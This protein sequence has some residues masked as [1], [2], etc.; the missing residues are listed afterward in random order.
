VPTN[1]PTGLDTVGAGGT[2][3]PGFVNAGPVVNPAQN[4]DAVIRNN[5]NLGLIATQTKLGIDGDLT[6]TSVDWGLLGAGGTPNQGLQFAAAG[7]VF[8]GQQADAG[9]FLHAATNLPAFH[10]AGD[11]V[12]TYYDVLTTYN[13]WLQTNVVFN[14]TT[15]T[16]QIQFLNAVYTGTGAPTTDGAVFIR[17]EPAATSLPAL[18]VF[19]LDSGNNDACMGIKAQAS[20]VGTA[21]AG[22]AYQIGVYSST[23]ATSVAAAIARGYDFYAAAPPAPAGPGTYHSYGFYS[24]AGHTYGFY[25]VS[26][27]GTGFFSNS[28]VYGFRAT[29]STHG[30]YADAGN[31]YNIHL[32]AANLYD[33]YTAQTIVEF[34]FKDNTIDKFWLNSTGISDGR[35]STDG[36]LALSFPTQSHAVAQMISSWSAAGG[37]DKLG[38]IAYKTTVTSGPT[39]GTVGPLVAAGVM[40]GYEAAHA[41]NKDD[42]A[43]STHR[44]FYSAFTFTN[45]GGGAVAD[46]GGTAYGLHINM[47]ETIENTTGHYHNNDGT[48]AFD[49]WAINVEA[50]ESKL[51]RTLIEGPATLDKAVLHL[52]QQ[53]TG[54]FPIL[55]LEG[56]SAPD[57]TANFDTAAIA[58]FTYRGMYRVSVVDSAGTLNAGTYWVPLY[59]I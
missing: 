24:A 38:G 7:A 53:N 33:I 58:G 40:T 37:S 50:G 29:G 23:D 59:T 36:M 34:T 39:A 17:M 25:S 10:Y 41:T 31:D 18:N 49:R 20:T 42:A 45:S 11:V 46:E 28:D 32:Q 16:E 3:G 21:M 2:L 56:K 15:A 8:P 55:A 48:Y 4:I 43:T 13:N 5:L 19:T 22:G 47:P 30:F 54:A 1:F 26:S 35:R 51:R 27:S 57:T 14:T 6:P 9:I 52:N 44:S 12:A